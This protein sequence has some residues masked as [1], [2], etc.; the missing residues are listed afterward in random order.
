MVRQWQELFFNE[1]YSYS[2]LDVVPDFVA[3]A[4][5]YG[6]VGLR[7]SKPSEVEPVLKE[8]FKVK[9]DCLHRFRHR[10]EGKVY[11]WYRLAQRWMSCSSKKKKRSLKESLRLSSKGGR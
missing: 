3:L 11:P 8:A 6:A 1:R 9:K 5:A 10:L 2:N 7:A 4:Q